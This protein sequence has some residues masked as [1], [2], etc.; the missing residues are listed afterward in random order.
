[1]NKYP[2]IIGIAIVKFALKN[3]ITKKV[4]AKSSAIANVIESLIF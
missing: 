4:T 2:A 3:Q 1:M